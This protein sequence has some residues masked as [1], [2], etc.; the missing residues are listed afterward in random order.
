MAPEIVRKLIGGV[1]RTVEAE[2]SAGGALPPGGTTG[3]VLTKASSADGDADWEAGGGSQPVEITLTAAQI[4][5]RYDSDA[6]VAA[7]EWDA[8]DSDQY[9]VA[10]LIVDNSLDND[11][12]IDNVLC[13]TP[14]ASSADVYNNGTSISNPLTIGPNNAAQQVAIPTVGG[15][16]QT[17]GPAPGNIGYLVSFEQPT[18]GSITLRLLRLS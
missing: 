8:F 4:A 6:G 7:L 1:W 3:Q 9:V 14:G 18:T 2:Q 11:A 12:T 13:Y 16:V 5:D 15:N 17:N 10:V